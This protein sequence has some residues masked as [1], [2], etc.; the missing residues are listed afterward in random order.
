ML[1]EDATVRRIESYLENTMEEKDRQ[2]FEKDLLEDTELR[3]AHDQFLTLVS[4]IQYASRNEMHRKLRKIEKE[5]DDPEF[6]SEAPDSEDAKVVRLWRKPWVTSVAAAVI[7]LLIATVV[8][9]TGQRNVPSEELFAQSFAPYPNIVMATQRG[10]T[11][12]RNTLQ[13]AF[14]AYDRENYEE[15]ITFFRRVPETEYNA[16]V[17]L[18]MGNAYL[19]TGKAGDAEDIFKN[20]IKNYEQFSVQAEW[21]L[22]LSYLKQGK[23]AEAGKMLQ[24]LTK[25]ENSYQEDAQLILRK[26]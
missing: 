3:K 25:G 16:S 14:Y 22:A 1:N 4:G 23:K 11:D 17:L 13:K 21:Y 6:G 8:L 5:L 10:G 12:E 2:K 7:L 15:A 19:A 18:Y 9:L 20:V 24:K 26:L